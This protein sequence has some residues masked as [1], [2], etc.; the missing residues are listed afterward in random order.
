MERTLKEGP[1][2]LHAGGEPGSFHK[3]VVEIYK[4]E[5]LARVALAAGSAAQLVGHSLALL[6]AQHQ[7]QQPPCILHLQH[8]PIIAVRRS[9]FSDLITQH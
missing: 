7:H 8:T 9:A 6:H 1:R 2:G 5:C 3:G 4:G